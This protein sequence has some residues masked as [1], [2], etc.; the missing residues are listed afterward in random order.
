MFS[1]YGYNICLYSFSENNLVDIENGTQPI[2]QKDDTVRVDPLD[3]LRKYRGGYEIRDLHY[4]SVR[5][6]FLHLIVYVPVGVSV[7]VYDFYFLNRLVQST[8]YTGVPG[9]AL[10]VL[11]LLCGILYA[12]YLLVTKFCFKCYDKRKLRKRSLYSRQ[13]YIWP[14]LVAVFFTILAM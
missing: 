9:Y 5:L 3:H 10:G 12:L 4:W 1:F 11:W 7:S 6:H 14:V 2:K 13:Y 8:V